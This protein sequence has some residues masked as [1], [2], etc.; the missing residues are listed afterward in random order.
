MKLWTWIGGVIG[1]GKVKER[2]KW[3]QAENKQELGSLEKNRFIAQKLDEEG[4][5]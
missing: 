2:R 5:M 4:F 3:E 1:H